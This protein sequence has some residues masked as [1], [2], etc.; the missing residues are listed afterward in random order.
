MHSLQPLSNGDD[1]LPDMAPSSPLD[2][3]WRAFLCKS[4]ECMQ[5]LDSVK[6]S[7]SSYVGS[8]MSQQLCRL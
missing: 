6:V 5:I 8:G 3:A 2:N 4:G 7:L 1:S